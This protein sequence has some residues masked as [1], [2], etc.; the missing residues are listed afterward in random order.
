VTITGLEAAVA[1]ESVTVRTT[2]NVLVS[3]VSATG[4]VGT[5]AVLLA[6]SG[7]SATGAVGTVLVRAWSNIDDQTVTYTPVVPTSSSGYTPV[8]P[9]TTNVWFQIVIS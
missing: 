6:I 9:D 8:N 7:V 2:T 1:V 3:G 5:A 4:A